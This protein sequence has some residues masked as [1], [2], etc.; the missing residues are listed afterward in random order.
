MERFLNKKLDC[1]KF[2]LKPF[3]IKKI[4]NLDSKLQ[5][6]DLNS[7]LLNIFLFNFL[8]INFL[9]KEKKIRYFL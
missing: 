7:L 3:L 8:Q 4:S 9:K 6:K 2:L 5:K 1:I